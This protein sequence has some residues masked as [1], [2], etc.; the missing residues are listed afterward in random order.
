MLRQ[1]G[2][3]HV[4]LLVVPLT[5]VVTSSEYG[6]LAVGNVEDEDVVGAAVVNEVGDNDCVDVD[7]TLETYRSVSEL[8]NP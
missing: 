6:E 4:L 1:P 3:R 7:G 5:L 2:L 8:V